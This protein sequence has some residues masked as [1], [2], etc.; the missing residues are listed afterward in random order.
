MVK[1]SNFCKSGGE[2]L[3]IYEKKRALIRLE[4]SYV[5][6]GDECILDQF[7][8]LDRLQ[9]PDRYYPDGLITGNDRAS[10][11]VFIIWQVAKR[12]FISSFREYVSILK[13]GHHLGT[14]G[15]CWVFKAR[16]KE[17]KDIWLSA[18]HKELYC[19]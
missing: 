10:D 5:Y 9:E 8:K 14:K 11:C 15:T 13:L 4:D 7:I 19:V 2:T 1:R 6:T 12:H 17:E 16:N 18:L 3:P